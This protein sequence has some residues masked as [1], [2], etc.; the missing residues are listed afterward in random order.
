MCLVEELGSERVG[1]ASYE[2]GVDIDSPSSIFGKLFHLCFLKY[3]ET[4]L[5]V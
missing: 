5:L 4:N 1:L 2:G 3:E